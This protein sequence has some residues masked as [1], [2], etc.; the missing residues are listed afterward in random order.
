MR[1]RERERERE[2]ERERERIV[3]CSDYWCSGQLC[4]VCERLIYCA[5]T[6]DQKRVAFDKHNGSVTVCKGTDGLSLL[7][8]GLL[9][10]RSEEIE[11]RSHP[12]LHCYEHNCKKSHTHTHT[13]THTHIMHTHRVSIH[14]HIFLLGSPFTRFKTGELSQSF[15][16]VL[17][18]EWVFPPSCQW[19]LAL[20][21]NCQVSLYN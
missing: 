13:H 19:V 9:L 15:V 16:G 18:S 1:E 11:H 3:I 2:K 6:A 12:L 10:P 4:V 20:C 17:V 21:G 8:G 14:I 7:S 5:V